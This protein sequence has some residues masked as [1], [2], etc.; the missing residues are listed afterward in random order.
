MKIK[1]L[2]ASLLLIQCPTAKTMGVSSGLANPFAVG[3]AAGALATA[4]TVLWLRVRTERIFLRHTVIGLVRINDI[5]NLDQTLDDI[6]Y[7]ADSNQ[8]YGIMLLINS[9]GGNF[10]TAAALHRE[11][12][13]QKKKKPIVAYIENKCCAAAYYIASACDLIVAS[14]CAEVGSIGVIYP[15]AYLDAPQYYMLEGVGVMQGNWQPDALQAG[16]YKMAGLPMRPMNDNERQMQQA[17]ID[18]MYQTM[19]TDIAQARGLSL[20]ATGQWADG[21]LFTARYAATVGLVD[22]LGALTHGKIAMQQIFKDRCIKVPGRIVLLEKSDQQWLPTWRSLFEKTLG[23]QAQSN[24]RA[25][26]L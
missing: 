21:Q 18:D 5:Q 22:L 11:L 12:L 23:N 13:M 19:C 20:E 16:A 15:H 3:L 25:Q 7:F 17:L 6:E 9:D 2:L 14:P 1:F 26:T 10:G 24:I 8:F 4:G